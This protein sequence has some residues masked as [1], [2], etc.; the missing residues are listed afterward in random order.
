[1]YIPKHFQ[2][3]DIDVLKKLINEYPLATIVINGHNGLNASHIPFYLNADS[4]GKTLLQGHIAK[5]NSLWQECEDDA[6]VICI[7]HGPQTYISPNWYETKKEH[8]KVVP[9]WNY[10]SVHAHG[11]LRLIHDANWKLAQ[12]NHLTRQSESEQTVPW[13][14]SDAPPEFI[15][16]LLPA[17]VGIEIAVEKLEGQ[18]KLSQNQPEKNQSGVIKGLTSSGK[19]NDSVIAQL[20]GDINNQQTD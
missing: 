14:V 6:Q 1:M 15:E 11:T 3:D 4:S 7:F 20:I 8:G 19:Y 18:W 17:I 16:K 12:I 13:S 2:Q 5:A 10:I 9:T